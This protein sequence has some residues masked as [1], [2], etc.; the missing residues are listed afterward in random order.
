MTATI[1]GTAEAAKLL[2]VSRSTVNRRAGLGTL[3]V[4]K[5]L[6]GKLGNYLFDREVLEAIAQDE[7]V[8]S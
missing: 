6:P 5:K 2:G 8:A 3:P 4:V 7:K 1:I